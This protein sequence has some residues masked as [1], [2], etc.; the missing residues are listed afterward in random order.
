MSNIISL[1]EFPDGSLSVNCGDG[2]FGDRGRR[3]KLAADDDA[4]ERADANLAQVRA[5]HAANVSALKQSVKAMGDRLVGLR[6]SN[7]EQFK[8]ELAEFREAAS[9]FHPINIQK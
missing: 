1:S 7:P 3:V 9:K 8:R 2:L 6:H 4:I 5:E